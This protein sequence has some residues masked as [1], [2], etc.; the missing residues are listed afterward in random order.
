MTWE[1]GSTLPAVG[2]LLRSKFSHV[3]VWNENLDDEADELSKGEFMIVLGSV[4]PK[5]PKRLN[6]EFY[7]MVLT[8]NKKIGWVHLDNCDAVERYT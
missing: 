8:Q 3:H 4:H 5:R 7:R 1:R 6:P 2:E